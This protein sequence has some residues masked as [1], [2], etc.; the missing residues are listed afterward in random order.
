M[1]PDYIILFNEI[2]LI[3]NYFKRS[4]PTSI[5]LSGTLYVRM[6]MGPLHDVSTES[7]NK[8]A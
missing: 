6:H 4:I 1:M 5:S 2:R 7:K 8:E 3:S